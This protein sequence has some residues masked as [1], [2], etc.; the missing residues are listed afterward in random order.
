MCDVANDDN[1]DNNAETVAFFSYIDKELYI[2]THNVNL[3]VQAKWLLS[4]LG[5]SLY[6]HAR[7]VR[8]TKVLPH[9]PLSPV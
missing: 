4:G 6:V 8:V 2:V 9:Y 3:L 1:V 5:L 7:I